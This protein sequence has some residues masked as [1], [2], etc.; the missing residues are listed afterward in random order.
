MKTKKCLALIAIAVL[1]SVLCYAGEKSV[2]VQYFAVI[3]DCGTQ[4]QVPPGLTFEQT[5]AKINE[6][7]AKDCK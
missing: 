6:L 5:V 1:M 7:S 4:H 2:E 3:T